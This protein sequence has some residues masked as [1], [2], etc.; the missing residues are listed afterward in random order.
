MSLESKDCVY[1]QFACNLASPQLRFLIFMQI[2]LT[3][4]QSTPKTSH[5][6]FSSLYFLNDMN[7]LSSYFSYS[8]PATLQG[9]TP[10]NSPCILLVVISNSTYLIH[11]FFWF[12]LFYM[13]YR[14]MNNLHFLLLLDYSF[15]TIEKITI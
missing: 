9:S 5:Y 6:A 14:I 11:P 10:L 13:S 4:P 7:V 3:I 12:S 2:M 15:K 8:C 1:I